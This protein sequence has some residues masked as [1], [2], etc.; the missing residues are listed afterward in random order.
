MAVL[1][2]IIA[3][4]VIA[5]IVFVTWFAAMVAEADEHNQSVA[6]KNSNVTI[7][8]NPRRWDTHPDYR[9]EDL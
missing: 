6:T 7:H 9:M 3:I 1:I 8:V 4:L 2:V 5:L